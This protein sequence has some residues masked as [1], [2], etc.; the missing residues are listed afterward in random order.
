MNSL[1]RGS[2]GKDDEGGAATLERADRLSEKDRGVA[3]VIVLGIPG[4]MPGRADRLVE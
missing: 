3:K 2:M 1:W 4:I